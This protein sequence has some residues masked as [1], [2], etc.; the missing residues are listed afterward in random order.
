MEHTETVPQ[1]PS[2]SVSFSNLSKH[3]KMLTRVSANIQ[4][5]AQFF[6]YSNFVSSWNYETPEREKVSF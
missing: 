6:I 4:A 3:S 1:Y 5:S 2:D